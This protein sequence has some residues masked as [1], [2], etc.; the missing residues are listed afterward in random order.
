MADI[1][2]F[3]NFLYNTA[4]I[5]QSDLPTNSQV[6]IDA[7]NWGCAMVPRQFRFAGCNVYDLAVYNV[8][9]S[10]VFNWAPDQPN[11]TYFAGQRKAWGLLNLNAGILNSTSDETTSSGYTVPD[12]AKNATMG[13]LQMLKDPFGRQAL[14]IL[15][16]FGS[17]WGLS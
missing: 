12:W 13:D 10:Y 14:A 7:F 17:L 3:T 9:A 8:G 4:G 2:D 5:P 1:T 15:Q 6:I 11:M 16:N